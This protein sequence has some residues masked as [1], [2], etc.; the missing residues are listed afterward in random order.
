M[1]Y[2][3][4]TSSFNQKKHLIDCYEALNKQTYKNFDWIIADDGST[5]G[6]AEFFVDKFVNNI[7]IGFVTQPNEGYRL[8]TILNKAVKMS[9]SEYVIFIMGDSFPKEDFIEQMDLVMQPERVVN[10]IRMNVDEYGTIISPDWRLQ[11]FETHNVDEEKIMYPDPWRTMTLNSMGMSRFL[12][13]KIDGMDE[14]Y[15]LYGREDWDLVMRAWFDGAEL[16]WATKAVIY[17]HDH[18]AKEDSPENI[19]RFEAKL[20]ILR[21][22]KDSRVRAKI[23][24]INSPERA[25]AKEIVQKKMIDEIREKEKYE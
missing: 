19:Q 13:D 25:R 8:S 12:W 15:K 10:G 6:T 1:K 21:G 9:T 2:T 18:V 24:K 22:D 3:V 4:I 7:P 11:M 16:W 14:S 23:E 20:A 5:D 17:H